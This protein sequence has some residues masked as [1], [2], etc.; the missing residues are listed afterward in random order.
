MPHDDA[1]PP[2]VE[3]QVYHTVSHGAAHSAVRDLPHLRTVTVSR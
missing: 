2:L 1:D 3:D